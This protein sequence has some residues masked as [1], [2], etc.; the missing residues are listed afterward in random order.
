M[1]TSQPSLFE[2]TPGETWQATLESILDDALRVLRTSAIAGAPASDHDV[3]RALEL[4]RQV[5]DELR[6][7]RS[8]DGVPF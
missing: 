3:D 4:V 5:A 8:P 1:T 6:I 7:L 2:G